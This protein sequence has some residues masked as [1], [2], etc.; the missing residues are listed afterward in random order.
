M[1]LN[2]GPTYTKDL[3]TRTSTY[4][5]NHSDSGQCGCKVLRVRRSDIYGNTPRVETAIEGGYQV[6]A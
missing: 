1:P 2:Y 4:I 6:N 5:N 3:H